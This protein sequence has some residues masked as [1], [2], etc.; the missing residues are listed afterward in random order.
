MMQDTRG[1]YG[2]GAARRVRASASCR[3]TAPTITNSCTGSSKS[4]TKGKNLTATRSHSDP[5]AASN[6]PRR[7][8]PTP[9]SSERALT[10][11][12]ARG[13]AQGAHEHPRIL[14]LGARLGGAQRGYRDLD[15]RAVFAARGLAQLGDPS[16]EHL[17]ARGGGLGQQ[18]PAV[19]LILAHE[20]I[21]R[22]DQGPQPLREGIEHLRQP[23]PRQARRE[24]VHVRQPEASQPEL[25]LTVAPRDVD[26]PVERLDEVVRVSVTELVHE[27]EEIADLSGAGGELSGRG[28][29]QSMKTAL[30][31][32][33]RGRDGLAL[34]TAA[35]D[36][37]LGE[38]PAA[39]LAGQSLERAVVIDAD[40]PQAREALRAAQA[41]LAQV[42][43]L[44]CHVPAGITMQEDLLGDV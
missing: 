26:E 5:N 1:K 3:R 38:A 17:H 9:C 7:V 25:Y 24:S 39:A 23:V 28:E 43:G 34:Q 13:V 40:V 27:L 41:V 15:P 32:C 20:Q 12:S 10:A 4:S 33:V 30:G 22:A 2:T 6:S 19:R 11:V 14:D 29:L 37:R 16:E 31:Q 36:V 8:N 21:R 44:R 18:Q 35:F 42:L